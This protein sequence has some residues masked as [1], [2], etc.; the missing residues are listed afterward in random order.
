MEHPTIYLPIAEPNASGD[1]VRAWYEMTTAPSVVNSIVDGC[2][3]FYTVEI[4]A[5]NDNHIGIQ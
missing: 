2:D 1:D 3:I 4:A 5:C